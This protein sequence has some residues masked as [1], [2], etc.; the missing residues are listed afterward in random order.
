LCIWNNFCCFLVCRC[1]CLFTFVWQMECFLQTCK[2]YLSLSFSVWGKEIN[3]VCVSNW[4]SH[5]FFLH[6]QL[7]NVV[8]FFKVPSSS[9]F[10]TRCLILKTLL[11]IWAKCNS[12]FI[13]HKGKVL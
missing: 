7:L 4:Q 1:Q 5:R 11:C 2:K 10:D 13:T 9:F 6:W 12:F 3:F 8:N